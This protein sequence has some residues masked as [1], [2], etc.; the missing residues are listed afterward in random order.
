MYFALFAIDSFNLEQEN[1]PQDL[2]YR[3]PLKKI[4]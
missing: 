3:K 1:F 4:P 2:K